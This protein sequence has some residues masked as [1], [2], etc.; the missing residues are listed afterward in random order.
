MGNEPN[1]GNTHADDCPVTTGRKELW[2]S[3]CQAIS[4]GP[5]ESSQRD[6]LWGAVIE[7]CAGGD[8]DVENCNCLTHRTAQVSAQM[9]SAEQEWY[10][11]KLTIHTLFNELHRRL[12]HESEL[13]VACNR[14]TSSM[15]VAVRDQ[16]DEAHHVYTDLITDPVPPCD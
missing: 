4:Q 3:F 12:T 10:A 8:E 14:P 9:R 16:I 6:Y 2:E 11:S 15:M 13:F 1:W 7:W 5:S